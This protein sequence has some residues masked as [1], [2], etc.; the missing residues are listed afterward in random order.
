[1]HFAQSRIYEQKRPGYISP[2][3]DSSTSASPSLV[4]RAK[5]CTAEMFKFNAGI[6]A[7]PS[8][9][10]GLYK[11]Q[12]NVTDTNVLSGI[13]LPSQRG[14]STSPCNCLNKACGENSLSSGSSGRFL[15]KCCEQS[16]TGTER[17]F[18]MRNGQLQIYAYRCHCPKAHASG[19][20]G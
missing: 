16:Q 6:A 2:S 1:M 7:S 5:M 10:C 19:R 15:R 9:P 12:V 17:L 14:L 20:E 18:S 13:S 8:F 4:G 11:P 3:S